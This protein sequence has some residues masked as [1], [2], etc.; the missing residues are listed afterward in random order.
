MKGLCSYHGLRIIIKNEDVQVVNRFKVLMT[1]TN[2]GEYDYE[3]DT[4]FE[5]TKLVESGNKE[6]DDIKTWLDGNSGSVDWCILYKP[7]FVLFPQEEID[8]GEQLKWG[9][10]NDPAVEVLDR[11]K[12]LARDANWEIKWKLFAD[13]MPFKEGTEMV[14][15]LPTLMHNS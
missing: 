13:N 11:W 4:D 5:A 6:G 9:Y 8:I 7:E 14:C 15:D 12:E 3:E 10:R 2:V 1:L